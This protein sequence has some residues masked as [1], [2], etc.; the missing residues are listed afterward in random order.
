MFS[1]PVDIA[2]FP[3]TVWDV[4]TAIGTVGAVLVSLIF[5]FVESRR[6]GRAERAR[7]AAEKARLDSESDQARLDR[8]ALID[9]VA[10]WLDVILV[11]P[12][13][14]SHHDEMPDAEQ[15]LLMTIHNYSDLPIFDLLPGFSDGSGIQAFAHFG[16][17][18]THKDGPV[19][20]HLRPG[21]AITIRVPDHK[22]DGRPASGAHGLF[23]FRDVRGLRWAR[24]WRGEILELQ[25]ELRF[26][27]PAPQ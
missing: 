19:T 4:L 11:T 13:D 5:A 7:D 22:P 10:V 9:K 2:N 18:Y 14:A 1:I 16:E 21:M 12:D 20:T 23:T 25:P 26:A 15:Q 8:Q 24:D 3:T 17:H 27:D 6:R